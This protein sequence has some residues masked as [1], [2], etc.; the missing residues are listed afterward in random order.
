MPPHRC[1]AA[2]KTPGRSFLGKL[3]MTEGAFAPHH[4]KMPTPVNPWNAEVWTGASSSRSGAATAAGLCYESLGSDTGG[5]I[6]FHRPP[7]GSNA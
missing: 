4:P 7:V 1:A 3:T 5:S 6:R 2:Q